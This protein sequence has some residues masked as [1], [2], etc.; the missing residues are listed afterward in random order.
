MFTDGTLHA[1]K[2]HERRD[3][4][5]TPEVVDLLGAWWGELGSPA[6]G[7]VSPGESV[8]G[9][10]SNSTILRREPYPAMIA[11]ASRESVP[12]A[13]SASSTP[14]VIRSPSEPSRAAGRSHGCLATLGKVTTDVYGHWERAERK[15][16]AQL[17][18]GI[19]G[20]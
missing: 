10:L 14:S 2:T 12:R 7:L 11:L 3:V 20:V 18:C 15:R 8:S 4:A 5:I 19:F 9:Y 6:E 13:R 17:M 16:E 1:S